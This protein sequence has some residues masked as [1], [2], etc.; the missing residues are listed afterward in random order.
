MERK[1]KLTVSVIY[2]IT[3]E[4]VQKLND[5]ETTSKWLKKIVIECDFFLY[6]NK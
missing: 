3:H 2:Q 1:W 5:G 4:N 6:L